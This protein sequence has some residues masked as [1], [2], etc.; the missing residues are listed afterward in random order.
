M[1]IHKDANLGK[2]VTKH[3]TFN[4]H[5]TLGILSI[6]SFIYRY[7]IVY[8]T[9][10]NLGMDGEVIDWLTIFIHTFLA[11][12]S[13]IFYVPKKRL[14][15]KPM[16]IYEEYR[17]HAIIFTLR[18]FFVFAI[19]TMFP[20]RPK[21]VVPVV[22]ATHH[23]IAD[24]ITKKHGTVGNTAVRSN[25][26]HGNF[27]KVVSKFYSFFQFLS[28]G[29][30]LSNSDRLGD[31]GYNSIIAIQSSAFAMTL[32]RKRIIN[33]KGH[34]VL[35]TFCLLVSMFHILRLQSFIKSLSILVVFLF[36][37]NLPSPLNNKYLLWSAYYLLS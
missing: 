36:R 15:A 18:C 17:Q 29:S 2:L 19:A 1:I 10:G 28:L 27:Y 21:Y 16:I 23:A 6:I 14:T 22:V 34:F 26:K 35:Y 5:K 37:I 24:G 20:V 9:Y 3:D 25:I 30:H 11:M 13:M 33:G 7:C 4:I 31:L 32:Y 8:S 12:T